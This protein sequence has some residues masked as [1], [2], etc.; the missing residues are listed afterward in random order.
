MTD[1]EVPCPSRECEYVTPKLPAASAIELL[2]IHE[3]TDHGK[4]A[5]ATVMLSQRNFPVPQWGSMNRLKSGRISVL[6]GSNT[7]KN[8]VCRERN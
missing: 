8:I 5:L 1:V 7:R 2:A 3:R 6:H 4:D